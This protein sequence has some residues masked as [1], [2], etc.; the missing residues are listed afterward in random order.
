LRIEADDGTRGLASEEVVLPSAKSH[1][2]ERTYE[3]TIDAS[4]RGLLVSAS[5]ISD[6]SSDD[7]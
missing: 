2:Y 5:R 3:L 7:Q 4:I 6:E 1:S